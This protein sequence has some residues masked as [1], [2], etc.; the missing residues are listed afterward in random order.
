MPDATHSQLAWYSFIKDMC[1]MG[2]DLEGP[3]YC[4]ISKRGAKDPIQIK[5]GLLQHIADVAVDFQYKYAQVR[6]VRHSR[7]YYPCKR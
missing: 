6:H 5:C 7:F 3:R 4:E 1:N 2:S